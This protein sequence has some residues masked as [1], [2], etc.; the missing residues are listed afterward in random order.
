MSDKVYFSCNAKDRKLMS[1]EA[2]I[3]ELEAERGSYAKIVWGENPPTQLLADA[4]AAER[5]R[6]ARVCDELFMRP[7]PDETGPTN[8]TRGQ[9][10]AAGALAASIRKGDNP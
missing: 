1:L 3:A 9:R 5:E 10:S 4:L 6:C 8:F 7:F 2:R